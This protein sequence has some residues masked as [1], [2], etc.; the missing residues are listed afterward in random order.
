M[1]VASAEQGRKSLYAQAHSCSV[2]IMTLRRLVSSLRLSYFV[3]SQVKSVDLGT[4]IGQSNVQ[5][6]SI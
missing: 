3:T 6:G 1:R 5:G 4:W 2:L